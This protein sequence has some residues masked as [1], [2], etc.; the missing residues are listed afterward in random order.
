LLA[1]LVGATRRLVKPYAVPILRILLRKADDPNPA[2]NA[3]VVMCLGELAAAGGEDIIPYIPDLMQVIIARLS[4]TPSRKRDA[5]LLSLG[6]V[7]S[8][9]GYVI[10]PLIDHVQLLPLLIGIMRTEN[11]RSVRREV[12][13]VLG[14]LGALDPFKRMVSLRPKLQSFMLMPS[15]ATY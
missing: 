3:N 1:R 9:T 6:Q 2:V 13:K 8:S 5:A 10:A 15:S 14:I 12:I 4:D 11:N 7:C